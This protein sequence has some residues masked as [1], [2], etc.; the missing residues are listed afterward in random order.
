MNQQS[1][2][3]VILG[4]GA[5]G[6]MAAI[7]AG[8]RG[9]RVVVLERAERP[10][11]KILI[12]GGGRCNFTN[13]HTR[14]DNF[15][16]ANPHFAK[17]A[18]ARYTPADFIRLV[19]RHCIAYHE[20]TLGQLFCNGSAQQI[21]DLL[22]SECADA[23]VRVLLSTAVSEV[24]RDDSS[25]AFTI[26]AGN[27]A[28]TARALMVAT[29]GLSIAKMGATGFGYDI[30]RQFRIPIEPCRP[31]L[32]PLTFSSAEHARFAGLAGVSAPVVAACGKQSFRE[33]MLFT[34]RGL[35]GPAILQISSYWSKPDAIQIDWAP[36][37]LLLAPLR[38]ANARRD[39]AAARAALRAQLPVRLADR[40]VD[41]LLDGTAPISWTNHALDEL[42]RRLHCFAFTPSGT[43]GYEKAE[44]TAGG[45]STSALSAQTM[46]CR[47]VRGLYFIGEV[48]D[49]TGHLGGF[50]FQWAWA[51]GAAAGRGV[52]SALPN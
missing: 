24:R 19:E 4:G 29:G 7:E 38:A 17:S 3:V 20:K 8:R 21:V 40:L 5:A 37:Q 36:E 49:V 6:L 31:A 46:E 32:V 42:E 47:S 10:G 44:V 12:S 9:R 28:F 45:V 25:G 1:F 34:H 2:D 30:A 52:Q 39:A 48:V 15:L 11:K 50:N 14:P 41:R 43:E 23:G 35:S 13:L 18:L 51:S 26:A 22:M 16:S 33:K 27:S